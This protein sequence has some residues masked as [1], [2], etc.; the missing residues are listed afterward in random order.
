M[1][2]GPFGETLVPVPEEAD[3]VNPVAVTNDGRV[4]GNVVDTEV[5]RTTAF[6]WDRRRGTTLIEAPGLERDHGDRVQRRGPRH[7]AGHHRRG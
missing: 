6:T 1:V 2:D 5:Y 7:R 3:S 4:T